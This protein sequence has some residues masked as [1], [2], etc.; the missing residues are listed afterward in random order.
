[1]S[2]DS[3]WARYR[4]ASDDLTG[5]MMRFANRKFG[6]QIEEA[7]LDF[8]MCDQP[9]PLVDPTSENQIFMPYF[10]FQWDP[11]SPSGKKRAIGHGGAVAQWYVMERARRLTEMDRMFLHQATTQP[12]SFHEVLSSEPGEGMTLRDIMIGTEIQVMEH[13]ASRALQQ[14][15]IT[16]AQVWNLNEIAILGCCAPIRIPPGR[17]ADVIALRKKLRK[18]VA[19]R[20]REL[21]AEDLLRYADDLRMTYLDIR[22]S[23][24]APTQFCN[25]DGDLLLFHTLTFQIDSPEAAFQAL[26]PL[27]LLRTKE[28][29]LED[30]DFDPA[31]NLSCLTFDWLKKGNRKHSTWD[32]TIMGTIKISA[33]YVVAEV[34]SERRAKRIRA[35]I[36][37]RLGAMATH[38]STMAQTR[39]ELL[40]KSP[41][42]KSAKMESDEEFDSAILK[43]PEIKKLAAESLQKQVEAWVHQKIPVLGNQTPLQAVRDS[44]GKEIVESLL[45]EWERR[46]KD[47]FFSGGIRP[48]IQAVRKLLNLAPNGPS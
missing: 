35:E 7:W 14:G 4:E 40:A 30:A 21:D 37:K 17:K 44:D 46:A 25:T 42:G 12:V 5:D 8:N 27:A 3:L 18:R 22:D 10:L 13:A 16:Y 33:N 36:E 9:E 34:N 31:G 32:N 15:D 23:L 11:L 43:D 24:Y 45:L 38:Q 19:Q 28:D 39:E 1:M 29:L 2:K 26:A 48:D 6:N 41:K 47:G 20:D